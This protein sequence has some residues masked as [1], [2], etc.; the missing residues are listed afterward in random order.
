MVDVIC[1]KI[2]CD[3][4]FFGTFYKQ[5]TLS[6]FDI[7]YSRKTETEQSIVQKGCCWRQVSTAD[8]K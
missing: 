5:T 2:K 3:F 1:Y 4:S 6:Y 8:T 7:F